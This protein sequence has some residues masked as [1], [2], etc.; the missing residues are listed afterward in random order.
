MLLEETSEAGKEIRDV[1]EI[2]SLVR[3][4]VLG[5]RK[6]EVLLSGSAKNIRWR[7]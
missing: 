7:V 1:L 2:Q 6:I 5:H 4:I 3:L